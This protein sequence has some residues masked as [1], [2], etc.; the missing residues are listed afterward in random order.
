[1]NLLLVAKYKANKI[2]GLIQ[3]YRRPYLV[4]G[5]VLS[6]WIREFQ[7]WHRLRAQ[8]QDGGPCQPG[9]AER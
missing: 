4:S 3:F 8:W 2:N 7:D 6:R 9:D 1:M 5:M